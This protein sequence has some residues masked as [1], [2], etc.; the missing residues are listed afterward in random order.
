MGYEL[1]GPP[2]QVTT[3]LLVP[4]IAEVSYVKSSSGEALITH[5]A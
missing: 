4:G 5:N 2:G 1:R 3:Y